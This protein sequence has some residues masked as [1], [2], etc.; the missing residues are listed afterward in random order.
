MQIIGTIL[1]QM[2]LTGGTK[3]R[4]DTAVSEITYEISTRLLCA[5][6]FFYAISAIQVQN[7]TK[8]L[9]FAVASLRKLFGEGPEPGGLLLPR[10]LFLH[11]PFPRLQYDIANEGEVAPH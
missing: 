10:L 9:V 6:V 5:C 2:S 1:V 4:I 8:N 3:S 11:I 7:L